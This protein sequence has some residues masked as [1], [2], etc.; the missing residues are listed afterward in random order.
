MDALRKHTGYLRISFPEGSVKPFISAGG[1][2]MTNLV[3]KYTR[4][5][6]T[7]NSM[8]VIRPFTDNSILLKGSMFGGPAGIGVKKDLSHKQSI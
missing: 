1:Y 3:A 8:N 7:E 2:L 6:E 5:G 4:E